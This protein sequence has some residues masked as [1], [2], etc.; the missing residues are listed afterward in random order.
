MGTAKIPLQAVL[1]EIY[2]PLR[3]RTSIRHI[4]CEP[5]FWSFPVEEQ[6][7]ISSVPPDA[8]AEQVKHA[9][10]MLFEFRPPLPPTPAKIF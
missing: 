6:M 9:L 7:F 10:S 2:F 1:I 8:A 3:F 5:H 4:E